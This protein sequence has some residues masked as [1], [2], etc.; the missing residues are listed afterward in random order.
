MGTLRLG[1][2]V[3]VPSVTVNTSTPP[4]IQSL[5]VTPST[6]S[7]TIT[8]PSG[9]DG[10]SP[11]S[12][13]AV[14]NTIDSNITANNIKSGVTIL[15]VTGTYEGSGG[16]LITKTITE[17]GVYNASSDNADGY[18]QVTVNV[19]GGRK[20]PVG[21][22]ELEYITT[23]GDVYIDTGIKLANTDIVEVEFKNNNGT[24]ASY[25]ALYGIYATGES[26]AFYANGTYYGYDSTNTQVNTNVAVDGNWHKVVHDFV[27]G[28]LTLDN[29]VTA[30]TPFTFTNTVNCGLCA[31]YSNRYGYFWRGSVKRFTVTRGSSAI[32]DLIPAIR[33]SDDAV[34]MYDIVRNQ[35]FSKLNSGA[36]SAG[37]EIDYGYVELPSYTIDENGVAKRIHSTL[38]GNEFTDISTID[39]N[40][41]QYAFFDSYLSGSVSFNNLLSVYDYGL[42]STFKNTN[43]TAASFPYLSYIMDNGFEQAFEN[44]SSLDYLDMANLSMV[45]NYGLYRAFAGTALTTVYFTNLSGLGNYALMETF[46]YCSSL[47]DIYFNSLTTSSFDGMTNQ[48]Q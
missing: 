42:Y 28:T 24:S 14:D 8:A 19:S 11:I 45:S 2:S 31:R 34:G 46:N 21:Y 37:P 36:F 1:S 33:K 25:G 17:N 5:S 6:S 10:Y 39:T 27:N 30:F 15:G 12:V 20:L 26:S 38:T 22:T 32:C 9:V 29:T 35:F 47:T 43:V 18:S 3:V 13:S 44:C 16:T 48:F 41:M 23:I 7:Q 4:V 40:A